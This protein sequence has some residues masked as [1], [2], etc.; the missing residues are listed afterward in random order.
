VGFVTGGQMANFTGLASARDEVLRRVGWD[1]AKDG[2]SGA[3]PLTVVVGE[4]AHATI[5]SALRMLGIGARQTRRVAVDDA[6]RMR[7]NDLAA[8]LRTCTGP[9]VVCCQLGNVN[10]GAFDPVRAIVA[11][12]HERGGWVHV[13]GTFGLWAAVHPRYGALVEGCEKAD[14]W[15]V[16]GHKWLNV[17]YDSGFAIVADAEAHRRALA[18]TS[19]HYL[20]RSVDDDRHSSDWVPES[21]RRARAFPVYAALRTLGRRGVADLVERCCTLAN[22]MATRLQALPGPTILNEVVLNQ[23]LVRFHPPGNSDPALADAMTRDVVDRIQ[24]EGTCWAGSTRWRG[25]VAMRIS[26]SNWST[27][28]DDIDRSAAAIA[29]AYAAATSVR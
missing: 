7:E 28:E 20:L 3:P 2:L 16:D 24:Q 25:H 14:S 15:S 29:R 12:G 13:D 23:V 9:L 5:H 26:V 27:Q 10:S 4:E 17:P 11:E 18:T 22:R 19:A 1:V 8:V 6:G 21:S